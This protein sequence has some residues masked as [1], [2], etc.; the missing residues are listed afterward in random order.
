MKLQAAF[1]FGGC[2]VLFAGSALASDLQLSNDDKAA[3]WVKQ[4][5]RGKAVACYNLGKEAEE[6]KPA[7]S[8]GYRAFENL[9]QLIDKHCEVP[10]DDANPAK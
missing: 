9:L 6:R 1:C 3:Q 10:N 7:N 8:T 4:V 5:K 2:L